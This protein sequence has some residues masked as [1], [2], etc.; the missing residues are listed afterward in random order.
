MIDYALSQDSDLST[1]LTLLHHPVHIYEAKGGECLE[2][3]L[4]SSV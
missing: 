1:G 2:A 3:T 4:I